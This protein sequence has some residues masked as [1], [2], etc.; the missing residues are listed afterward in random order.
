MFLSLTGSLRIRL[1]YINKKITA[2]FLIWF[3]FIWNGIH[4]VLFPILIPSKHFLLH[5]I[6]WLFMNNIL[7]IYFKH[8]FIYMWPFMLTLS[9]DYC[10]LSLPYALWANNALAD[11]TKLECCRGLLTIRYF[12]NS[13]RESYAVQFGALVTERNAFGYRKHNKWS[14]KVMFCWIAGC[15]V[16]TMNL[17]GW[18]QSVH[19]TRCSEYTKT[20]LETHKRLHEPI[21]NYF[22]LFFHRN[23]L[24]L[25][26]TIEN[27]QVV[28]ARL[29]II[30]N[31]K[32]KKPKYVIQK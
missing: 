18:C 23:E 20:S 14:K 13:A 9:L 19:L 5:I 17:V 30:I 3:T 4:Y 10:I 22:K 27:L 16:F 8:Q 12:R 25:T 28:K 11:D 32:Y 24:L 2:F 26:I 29:I 1:I 15:F 31:F 21:L 7:Y 6:L